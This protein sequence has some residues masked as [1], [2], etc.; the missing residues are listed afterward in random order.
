MSIPDARKSKRVVVKVQLSIA[1]SDG[2]SSMLVYDQQREH[3]FV[4]RPDRWLLRK[5]GARKK[6]FFYAVWNAKG[7]HWTIGSEANEQDW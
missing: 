4:G 3:T 2:K 7:C 6:A 5:M 1:S